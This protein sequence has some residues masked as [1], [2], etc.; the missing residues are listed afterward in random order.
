MLADDVGVDAARIDAAVLAEEMA[1]PCGVEDGPRSDHAL[2]QQSR[3]LP[4]R[5]GQHVHRV[6]GDEQHG[7]RVRGR[8]PRHHLPE[9]CRVARRQ[10]EPRLP[11]LLPR[12]GSQHDHVC[13][14]TVAVVAG[15][16]ASRVGEGHGVA[17][18]HRLALGPAAVCV[19]QH[20]LRREAVKHQSVG[21]GRA[22]VAGANN[23]D[24]E[25]TT[26]GRAHPC[27]QVPEEWQSSTDRRPAQETE[28]TSP[29]PCRKCNKL[30]TRP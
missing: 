7:L 4:R 30:T 8:D 25:E 12:S 19:D 22:H 3:E 15:P 23:D 27:R 21:Q 29:F 2:R 24:A 9:D 11:R 20:D 28:T 5:E 18:V 17:Q 10:I 6:G 1:E 13:R 16:D 14:L 26:G